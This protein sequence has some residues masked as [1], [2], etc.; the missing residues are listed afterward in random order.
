M[1]QFG[2]LSK[3][4]LMNLI[5]ISICL[6][7]DCYALEFEVSDQLSCR[8]QCIDSGHEFFSRPLNNGGKCCDKAS[9]DQHDV[10]G[11]SICD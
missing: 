2:I 11:K 10:S 9:Y 1:E 8:Q 7:F 4:M 5:V 6:T 3:S